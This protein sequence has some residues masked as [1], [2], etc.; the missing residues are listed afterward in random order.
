MLTKQFNQVVRAAITGK[1]VQVTTP[2]GNSYNATVPTT[3]SNGY[4]GIYCSRMLSIAYLMALDASAT[5]FSNSTM[6]G[7]FAFGTGTQQPTEDDYTITLKLLPTDSFLVSPQVVCDGETCTGT[8]T[9]INKGTETVTLTEVGLF[10]MCPRSGS[11]GYNYM[12]DRTLLE[13]PITIGPGDM[14]KIVYTIT[15]A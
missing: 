4:Q 15:F 12:I 3:M 9:I 13:Q 14:G 7:G 10:G 11:S 1:N 2:L 5:A 6:G 8:Y